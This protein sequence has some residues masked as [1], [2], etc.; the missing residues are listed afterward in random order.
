MTNPGTPAA[1]RH[2]P[3]AELASD[4]EAEAPSFSPRTAAAE[5]LA[6]LSLRGTV[7]LNW[8]RLDQLAEAHQEQARLLVEQA[9]ANAQYLPA[10]A[11]AIAHEHDETVEVAWPTAE[12]IKHDRPVLSFASKVLGW[13]SPGWAARFD[14]FIEG[15]AKQ[16]IQAIARQITRPLELL[17]DFEAPQEQILTELEAMYRELTTGSSQ[18]RPAPTLWRFAQRFNIARA[19]PV[20][21]AATDQPYGRAA[22]RALRDYPLIGGLTDAVSKLPIPSDRM[23]ALRSGMKAA[24]PEIIDGVG[25]FLR[26]HGRDVPATGHVSRARTLTRRAAERFAPQRLRQAPAQVEAALQQIYELMPANGRQFSDDLYALC[27]EIN[28]A[29]RKG[30]DPRAI[31]DALLHGVRR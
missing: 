10:L 24:G 30:A 31:V 19:V 1:E 8:T 25:K 26:S 3:Q 20:R 7:E 5:H 23:F 17:R 14:S 16:R 13:L 29:A 27:R 12:T 28:E 6:R 15:K 11:G 22:R 2:V 21:D 4:A 9:F 18:N